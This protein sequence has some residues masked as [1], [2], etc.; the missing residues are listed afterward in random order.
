MDEAGLIAHCN[1]SLGGDR[2]QTHHQQ[3][4]KYIKYV[5]LRFVKPSMTLQFS[6]SKQSKKEGTKQHRRL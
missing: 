4:Y 6:R 1:A 3:K 5:T 2:F